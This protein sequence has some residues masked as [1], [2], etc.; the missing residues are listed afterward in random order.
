[1]F[2][3]T[4][5]FKRISQTKKSSYNYSSVNKGNNNRS[6][7]QHVPNYCSFFSFDSDMVRWNMFRYQFI[8]IHENIC[9]WFWNS[10]TQLAW[11]SNVVFL[12]C[13]LQF[14]MIMMYASTVN[15]LVANAGIWSSCFFEEITNITAFHNVIVRHHLDQTTLTFGILSWENIR[16]LIYISLHNK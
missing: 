6:I 15:H 5:Q 8:Y 12:S 9:F 1:M 11:Y 2:N 4:K 3:P 7:L 14:V 16:S 13:H 10:L